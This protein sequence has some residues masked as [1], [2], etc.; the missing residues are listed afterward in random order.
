ML[1]GPWLE[2][3]Q[4]SG[5]VKLP[6]DDPAGMELLCRI[7]YHEL[8]ADTPT[9]DVVV[10]LTAVCDKYDLKKVIGPRIKKWAADLLRKDEDAFCP[11]SLCYIGWTLKDRSFF[12]SAWKDLVNRSYNLTDGPALVHS[13]SHGSYEGTFPYKWVPHNWELQFE[14]LPEGT[15]EALK[16]AVE[17]RVHA[18]HKAAQLFVASR[19]ELCSCTLPRA[20]TTAQCDAM[21]MGGLITILQD[22]GIELHL[23]RAAV[24]ALPNFARN[25]KVSI[26]QLKEAWWKKSSCPTL[27][28]H[29]RCSPVYAWRMRLQEVVNAPVT[30][31]EEQIVHFQRHEGR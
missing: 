16:T 24:E 6:E 14:W 18:L 22:C 13:K 30:L 23:S 25:D 2:A 3:Q 27:R 26:Q 15:E 8:P 28:G 20:K 17:T 10:E 31:T 1:R 29:E 12:E 9:A 7:L 21:I 11:D 4:S 19:L 5:P